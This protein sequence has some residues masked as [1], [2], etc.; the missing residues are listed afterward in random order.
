MKT[1]IL[2]AVLVLAMAAGMFTGLVSYA[3]E[4]SYKMIGDLNKDGKI[5]VADAVA[6][7]RIAAGLDS[8][9]P[10]DIA[11]DD[12][13]GD[14]KMTVED[15]IQ[16]LR[17]SMGMT[18]P[19]GY[20]GVQL[21]Y[22]CNQAA[23]ESSVTQSEIASSVANK[24]NLANLAKLMVRA[25]NGGRVRV[26]VLGG[27]I[28]A[29]SSA[30]PAQE[31][32]YG[33]LTYKWWRNTF[34]QASVSFSNMGIGATTSTLG[35]H[36]LEADVLS[37]K[38]DFVIV[39]FAVNDANTAKDCEAYEDIIRRLILSNPEMAIMS[40]YM[41]QENKTNCQAM[42]S[43]FLN[44]YQIPQI[45]YHNVIWDM[46]DK[47]KI[48]KWSDISPDNIH[49]NNRGHKLCA[50]LITS[51]LEAV[52]EKADILSKVPAVMPEPVYG[53]RYMNAKLYM[54]G[55]IKPDSM[56]NW[57]EGSFVYYHLSGA[58]Q[59]N[60][61]TTK[62]ITFT[63][64]T[65][66]VS[67]VIKKVSPDYDPNCGSITVSIDGKTVKTIDSSWPNGWGDYY[68]ALEPVFSADEAAEHTIS[69]KCNGGNFTLIGLL[70]A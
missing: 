54:G 11:V 19:F 28:T 67:L 13:T 45:S 27:S 12:V 57:T 6:E 35:V 2:A 44:E 18:D 53:E 50:S 32:C 17:C 42:E 8:Y 43:Q 41:T 23:I 33:A 70:I 16:L 56:G 63:F 38:P 34:P 52:K 49:P 64:T 55:S 31:N 21:D 46:I 14:R 5:T 60:K 62:P 22:A 39:E 40:L 25:Q 30:D 37:K 24:G 1:R 65:Q 59:A 7:L 29:G 66:E 47:R 58:W 20:A 26:V 10:S 9:A 61:K 51:F 36:R 4:P 69:I 15:A 68:M 3:D 48:I